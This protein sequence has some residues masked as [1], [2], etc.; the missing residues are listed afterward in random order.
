MFMLG[1][2]GGTTVSEST[3]N[4]IRKGH[5]MKEVKFVSGSDWVNINKWVSADNNRESLAYAKLKHTKA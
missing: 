3:N 2:Y 4:D 1:F 5:E